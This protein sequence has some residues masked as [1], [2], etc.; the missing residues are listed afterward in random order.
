MHSVNMI[1]SGT[2]VEPALLKWPGPGPGLL[3]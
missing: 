3:A 2:G 1:K